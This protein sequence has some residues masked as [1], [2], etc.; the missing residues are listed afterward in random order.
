MQVQVSIFPYKRKGKLE[1]NGN[2]PP[3]TLKIEER[4]PQLQDHF[5]KEL[6]K[7]LQYP[8]TYDRLRDPFSNRY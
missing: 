1:L 7:S 4:I 5:S 8:G 3:N 2:K 6:K